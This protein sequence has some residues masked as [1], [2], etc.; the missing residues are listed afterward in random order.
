[1]TLLNKQIQDISQNMNQEELL[2]AFNK[3]W[4]DLKLPDTLQVLSDE[5]EKIAAGVPDYDSEDKDNTFWSYVKAHESTGYCYFHKWL[6][7]KSKENSIT[8]IK[9]NI[10]LRDK[11]IKKVTDKGAVIHHYEAGG[12]WALYVADVTLEEYKGKPQNYS[13]K[14]TKL[15]VVLDAIKEIDYYLNIQWGNLKLASSKKKSKIEGRK[16]DNKFSKT[17]N[18]NM[19][20]MVQTKYVHHL[21]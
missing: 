3:T 4:D 15:H 13:W 18:K 10:K 17:F 8:Y 7:K 5:H 21:L 19:K 1:M 16:R 20:E 6:Q 11:S 14:I 12:R 2:E 9:D